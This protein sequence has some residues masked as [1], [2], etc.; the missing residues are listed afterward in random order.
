MATRTSPARQ[1]Q[2]LELCAGAGMLG[3]GLKLGLSAIGV[4]SRVVGYVERDA[5][6]ASTLVARMADQALDQAPVCDDLLGLDGKA[7]RGRVDAIAAGIPCQGN[8]TAGRRRLGTD[9]RNL[10]P[11]TR[12]ILREVE[13]AWFLL[14]NVAGFLIPNRTLGL[15]APV[16]RVLGELAEDGWDAEWD[17]VPAA[18]VGASHRRERVFILARN[19]K[20]ADADRRQLPLAVRAAQA[21][22]G[23]GEDGRRLPRTLA[24]AGSDQRNDR[25]LG[26]AFAQSQ[27]ERAAVDAD[28]RVGTLPLFAPGP[29]DLPAWASALRVDPTLAPATQPA[30]HG[31]ADGLA[32]G[33]GGRERP[34]RPDELRVVGNGVCPLAAALAVVRLLARFTDEAPASVPGAL[35]PR[36]ASHGR[37]A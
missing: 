36:Q 29:A 14:E 1:I 22:A 34:T 30:V 8:S 27:A 31:V 20:L 21:R 12:R 37:A 32:E 23:L 18:E 9:A 19:A 13:P 6:A 33:M 4:G 15:E 16:A 5:Y 26:D 28:A 24:D 3:V 2:I 11:A 7:W 25:G 35:P 10:W 17:V